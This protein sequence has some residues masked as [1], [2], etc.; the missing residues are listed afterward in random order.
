[1]SR[2][3]RKRKTLQFPTKKWPLLPSSITIEIRFYTRWVF[4]LFS[5]I[6]FCKP[7]VKLSCKQM[8]CKTLQLV[9]H[10]EF[11]YRNGKI[12]YLLRWIHLYRSDTWKF[13]GTIILN[14]YKVRLCWQR[15]MH[16]CSVELQYFYPNLDCL[17]K[18]YIIMSFYSRSVFVNFHRFLLKFWYLGRQEQT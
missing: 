2:V 11:R 17:I 15:T 7:F 6:P 4:V 3:H 16:R 10:I 12:T 1:M 9:I 8:F 14:T 13:E 18:G 5:Q